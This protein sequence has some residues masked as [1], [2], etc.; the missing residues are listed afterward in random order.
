MPQADAVKLSES[1]E[2]YLEA[3]L[4]L[5][6]SSGVARAK[7][8]AERLGVARSS[9]T[10]ALRMLGERGLVNYRPYDYITL[11]AA[12]AAQADRVAKKHGVLTRFFVDVMGVEPGLAQEAAC[13]AEHALGPGVMAR[14][15]DFVDFAME[16]DTGG[17]SPASRFRDYCAKDSQ[18]LLKNGKC[19]AIRI[20]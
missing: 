12:G 2:D 9:V 5:A 11:T 10:G 18:T 7:D 13:K 20:K 6:S 16:P 19:K 15:V 17:R 4:H 8:V 1:L 14:L 3:I